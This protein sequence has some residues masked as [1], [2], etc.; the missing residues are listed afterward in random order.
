MG[1][2]SIRCEGYAEV[3]K[4]AFGEG[5]R[6]SSDLDGTDILKGAAIMALMAAGTFVAGCLGKDEPAKLEQQYR[7]RRLGDT[8]TIHDESTNTTYELKLDGL[9]KVWNH[10]YTERAH[11]TVYETGAQGKTEIGGILIEEMTRGAATGTTLPG[12][13]ISLL[14][15]D[16]GKSY[17]DL[18]ITEQ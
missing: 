5:N 13:K 3:G 10:G 17:V 4:T 1:L 18:K 14:D 7:F 12:T 9:E 6:T 11:F 2:N 16:I 15:V 8:K